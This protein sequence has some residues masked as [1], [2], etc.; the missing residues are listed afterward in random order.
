[1]DEQKIKVVVTSIE[2]N[3]YGYVNKLSKVNYLYERPDTKAPKADFCW[4]RDYAE[5]VQWLKEVNQL[6]DFEILWQS[7]PEDDLMVMTEDEF[8]TW[9]Y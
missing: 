8:N 7:W 4:I 6:H 5:F 2:G 1:M 3:H 9:M